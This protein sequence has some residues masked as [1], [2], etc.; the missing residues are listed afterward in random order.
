MA[1][2]TP[3]VARLRRLDRG[4]SVESTEHRNSPPF[5]TAGETVPCALV[6]PQ[7]EMEK[8]FFR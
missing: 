4:C 2:G 7:L 5:T 1:I 6:L 3:I 8:A